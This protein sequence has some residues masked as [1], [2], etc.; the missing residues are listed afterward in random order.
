MSCLPQP[1]LTQRLFHLRKE[2][3][4]PLIPSPNYIPATPHTDEESDPVEAS[5]TRVASPHSTTSPSESTSPLSP[6]HLL[7][8]QTSLTPTPSRSFYYCIIAR[9]AVRTQPTLSSGISARVTEAM[10]LSPSLFPAVEP[11]GLGY[12]AARHHVLELA[13]CTTHSTYEVGQSSISVPVQQ[14]AD[15]T[16]IPRLP[17]RTTWEDPVE[18]ALLPTLFE[19]CGRDFTELYARSGAVKEEIHSQQ[20][21]LKGMKQGQEQATITFGALWQ[22]VLAHEAWAGQTDAEREALWDKDLFKSKDPQVVVAAAKLPILNPNEF[23]VWKM[24][25]EQYFLMINYSLWEV[26]LK[27]DSPSPI[28]I[29]DGDVQIISPTTAKQRLAKKNKL[30]ARGILLMAL[31]DKHQLKFNIHKDAKSLME[32]I[33]KRFGG[34]KETKKVQKTFLKQ[35]YENFS[36]TSSESLDQIH[37]RLQKLI[38]Q[39]KILGKTISQEDINLKFLRSLPSDAFAASFKATVSTLPNVD[40]LSDSFQADEEPTNYALMAYASSGSS[41]S[42]GSDNENENVFEEDCKLIKLDVMLRDNA[43]LELRKKFE[44]A[45]KERDD[46]KL[47]LEN[48]QTSSKN[49]GKL[50]ECQVSDKTSLGYD[51]QVFNS[52]VFDCEE[53]H[54]HELDN[55]VPKSPENDMHK[56]SEGY[57]AVSPPYTRTFM[58]PKPDLVFND[59]PTA[60]ES[61][62]NVVN[63]E[64]SLNKPSKDMSK[65]LKPD[66]PIIEDWISDFED[67]TKNKSVP[68]P[69]EPSFVPTSKHVKTHREY[70]K[71]IQFSHG[72]GPQKTLSFL[73]DVHG[74]PQQALKDKGVI[75]SGFSRHMSRNISFL[76]DF[77]EINKGYVAFGGNPKVGKISGKGKIKTGKLDSDDVYFV[78]ELKFN[79]FSVK[80]LCDKKNNVLFT[81]TECVVLSSEYKLPDENHVLLRVPRENNIY[82]VD[83]KNVVPLGDLT[84]LFAKATLDESNLWHKRLGHINFKTMNKLV[85]G[86]L[87]RGIVPKLLFDIDTLTKSMNYQPVVAG[88]QP[89]D[90]AGFKENLD[91]D[92]QNTYADA[93][94]DVKENENDVY[95]ST[96]RSDKTDNTKHDEKAKREFSSN[97][98]NMVNDVSAPVTTAGPNP[99]NNT[100]SFNTDSLSDTAVSPNFRIARKSSFVDPSKYLDDPDMPE[101]EDIVYSD[102]KEDVGVDADLS[103]LETNISVS[104]IPTTRVY[105]DHPVTQIISNLTSAPQTRKKPKKVHLALK[106]P[107][108]IEAMQEE[109][110]QFKLQKVWVLVDLPKGKRAIC[111]KWVFKNKKNERGIVIRDKDRLVAQ[112]HT[113]EEGIDYDEVFV[114]VAKIEAIQLFLAYASFMGFMV[115]PMDVKSSF[116]YKIIKEEV[117]VCQPPGF[118]D[119][120]KV[121][122][123][124]I[125]SGSTNKELCKAFERLMKDKFQ[126]KSMGEL[127]FFLGLQVRQ[128]DNG[129]FI[130]QDKYVAEIL[131]KFGFTDVKSASTPIETE[132]PLLK[133]PDGEDVDVHICSKELASPKQMALG[134]DILNLFM[135]GS[136]P[137]TIWHFITAVSYKLMLFGLTKDAA[138]NLMLLDDADGVECFLNEEIF[139]ELA[140]MGYEKP[141]PKLT[142]YK[143][144]FFAQ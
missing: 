75:D 43:L 93:A 23:D 91:A 50:L 119:P 77:E 79:L 51:S 100:N 64:S 22:L 90:N 26:I 94:F 134:K 41:S 117:Y 102:A 11:L 143:A 144:F 37:D 57:H 48:F 97:N 38:S 99:T 101:L 18:D 116:L 33:E 108:W 138:I 54:S 66:A 13:E 44:K 105:K 59:A 70:V 39:L 15:E 9:M 80:Q 130:S 81:D 40:S 12:G 72:L 140:R 137:K 19:G 109:I 133:D 56:T 67:E 122:V 58:P 32:A 46:L 27:G 35:Q 71:K 5:E 135:A 132:N 2:S 8:T 52:Q 30:K 73:F 63:F 88:N 98:T 47:T 53:L 78:K 45:K 95:V 123:D 4:A 126:M 55:S 62:D 60:S 61:V 65:T 87:V 136:L 6:D 84:C 131:R 7:P 141:P 68:K 49:L 1:T 69:K 127:I 104:S 42:L 85:K 124:D 24:R 92:P 83:L 128:K 139:A 34:N 3:K 113:Q 89:N 106:D 25:I 20:F 76:S 29:V 125:I 14:T 118:E 96:R 82:N 86:S 111:S 31:L 28:R 21:R 16:T 17:I 110:L 121:Y 129:I 36:G 10:T 103:N 120:D 142:F 114:P 107:S 112:G 115:Y 74:N